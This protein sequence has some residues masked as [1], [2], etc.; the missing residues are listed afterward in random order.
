MFRVD[1]KMFVTLSQKG[2]AKKHEFMV[3]NPCSR[4]DSIQSHKYLLQRSSS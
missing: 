2:L 4:P 1:D 3:R